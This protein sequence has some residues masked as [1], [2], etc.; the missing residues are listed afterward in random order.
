MMLEVTVG[1]YDKHPTETTKTRLCV[2]ARIP[3]A[4][5]LDEI[6]LSK[7]KTAIAYTADNLFRFSYWFGLFSR[8]NNLL[9]MDKL[10]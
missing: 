3:N 6:A 5:Y 7:F 10:I 2:S 8:M 9:L 4:F 1:V